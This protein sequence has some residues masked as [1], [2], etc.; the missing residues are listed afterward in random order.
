MLDFLIQAGMVFSVTF[1]ALCL[2]SIYIGAKKENN[3]LTTVHIIL[4]M[5]IVTF[6]FLMS[7]EITTI[8]Y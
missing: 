5:C 4:P 1:V 8:L 7:I 6:V 2:M 3:T